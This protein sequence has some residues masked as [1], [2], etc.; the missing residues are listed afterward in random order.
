LGIGNVGIHACNGSN[1]ERIDNK[2]PDE[3]FKF[4]NGTEGVFRVWGI[5]DYYVEQVYWT[6]PSDAESATYPNRILV[7]NYKTGSWAFNIDT[8]TAFGY[9]QQ[10]DNVTWSSSTEQWQEA[11]FPWD[12]GVEQSHFKQVLAGN[13]EGFTFLILPDITRNAPSLQITNMSGPDGNGNVLITAINHN[14]VAGTDYVVVEEAQ[15]V[16][17]INGGIYQ[18][19][20]INDVNSFYINQPLM[21]GTYTGGGTLAR[22]SNIDVKTKQYNFY[23]QQGL[24][25]YINKVD[26]YVDKTTDGQITVDYSVSSSNESLLTEGA[27]NGCLLGNGVLETSPYPLI[28]Q[29]NSQTRLWHPIYP[30]AQGE[31]IQLHLYLTPDQITDPNIAWSDF[32]MHAMTFYTSPTGRLQ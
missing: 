11:M 6:F 4:Q 1:V 10:Q 25:A 20:S 18:V 8:I 23:V 15:G 31:V 28:P 2:I 24:N 9:F 19:E 12:S 26:F 7:Y 14:L 13:Q 30:F 3:V 17:N 27:G 32:Q 22:V 16:L 5:R 21:T 29:E